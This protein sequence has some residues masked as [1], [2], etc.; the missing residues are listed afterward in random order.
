MK[1]LLKMYA[2]HSK[3]YINDVFVCNLVNDVFVCNLDI[4]LEECNSYCEFTYKG[5]NYTLSFYQMLFVSEYDDGEGEELP[6]EWRATIIE[7]DSDSEGVVYGANYHVTID[8]SEYEST[9]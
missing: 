9:T 8:W 2:G 4:S 6:Y 3:L 5:K 1:A 7:H